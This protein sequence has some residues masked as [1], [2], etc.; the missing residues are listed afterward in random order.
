MAIPVP[1]EAMCAIHCPTTDAPSGYGLLFY[2]GM[3]N[4]AAE[5]GEKAER[6][7]MHKTYT[8]PAQ[9][10]MCTKTAQ[11]YIRTNLHAY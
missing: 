6:K 5:R 9:T 10:Y 1:K 7:W 2:S 11:T 3:R 8:K 4:T